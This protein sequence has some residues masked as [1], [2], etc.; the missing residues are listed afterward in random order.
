MPRHRLKK[1]KIRRTMR[2][3]RSSLH[4][5]LIIFLL[6]CTGVFLVAWTL[7][8]AAVDIKVTG[9]I[10]GPAV[11]EPATITDPVSNQRFKDIP[12]TVSGTCPA[13]AAYVEIFS[14]D[15]MK[16]AA[17]CDVDSKYSLSIDLFEGRNDLVAHVFNIT[18][19]EGPPSDTVTVFYDAPRPPPQPPP[20]QGGAGGP[21]PT[22][23]SNHPP[24]QPVQ[25]LI[26]KTAFLYKGYFVGDE[27]QWPLEISGGTAPYALSVDW[28]DGTDDVISRGK[29]GKLDISHIYAQAGGYQGSYIVKVKA[30]DSS[31]SKAYIQ[32]FVV[33]KEKGGNAGGTIFSKRPPALGSSLHWLLVAWPAYLLIVMMA[34]SYLLG[35][36]QELLILKKKGLLRH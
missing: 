32:F 18:D 31:G 3:N 6:L 2:R 36:R 28:G 29:A 20:S 24:V 13:N 19:D 30:T 21:P 8:A 5:P 17:I 34:V 35:E 14:N 7:R 26:L 22:P 33:V 16:G 9:R 11:T 4:Y 25:Q 27:L 12:I 1:K 10:P 15:V 23:G